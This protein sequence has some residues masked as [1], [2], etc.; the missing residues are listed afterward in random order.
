MGFVQELRLSRRPA[1]GLAACGAFWGSVAAWLP[2]IKA[3][4]G[5]SEARLGA[6]MMLSA[7]GGMIAMALAPRLAARFGP[8]ILPMAGLGVAVVVPL[9][10]LIGG[11]V[12]LALVLL[13]A[14]LA[15]SFCDILSNIRISLIEARSGQSLMN[16]NH[17]I[18]S[19]AMAGSAASMGLARQAG[20]PHIAAL[21]PVMA[22]VLGLVWI[23]RGGR[24]S[25][26]A[27]SASDKAD[28]PAPWRAI[29]PGAAILWLC[30]M[31]ENGTESWGALH[32]EH[33]LG[34]AAGLGAFGPAVFALAMGIARLAGQAATRWLGALRLVAGSALMALVGAVMLAA[35][36]DLG[37]AL[38]G[39]GALGVGL[40]V[41][42]PSTNS[43]LARGVPEAARA[44]AISRAWMLGFTGFF[45]GPPVMGLVAE[46]VGLRLAFA[47]IACMVA[48]MLPALWAQ[49]VLSR[50]RC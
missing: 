28:R 47:L 44:S 50:Q 24:G 10:A 35:A 41:I 4:A 37:L 13:A 11:P 25:A 23:M 29:L 22:A 42:V 15:M 17:A 9:P 46:G 38:A 40:A 39:A 49:G 12:A 1:A 27:G 31:A 18:F 14:G 26:D 48:L 19:L 20:V 6:M 2:Q 43:L 32:L 21:L 8:A 34:V 5:V 7:A 45:I 33:S 3:A 36:S 30:F 16:L